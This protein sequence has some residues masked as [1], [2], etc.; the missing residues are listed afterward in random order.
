MLS[1]FSKEIKEIC[2]TYKPARNLDFYTAL[3]ELAFDFVDKNSKTLFL[4][5]RFVDLISVLYHC[6]ENKTSI[7]P[8]MLLD[9]NL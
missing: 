6:K 4:T 2:K 3:A 5:D 8:S 7:N 1:H 9:L